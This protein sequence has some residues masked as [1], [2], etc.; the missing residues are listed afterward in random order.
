MLR[1]QSPSAPLRGP[2]DDGP[3]VGHV[4]IR[5][6]VAIPLRPEE[7]TVAEVFKGAG[8]VTGAV[9][10]WGW[11]SK[12]RPHTGRQGFDEWF[13]YLSQTHAHDY[14]PTSSGA[15]AQPDDGSAD[16]RRAGSAAR[17]A[18]VGPSG[19]TPRALHH[20]GDQ[21]Y[22]VNKSV[23][24][25][26]NLACT[27]PHANNELKTRAWKCLRRPVLRPH[28]PNRKE[29]G[30]HITRLD[31]DVAGWWPAQGPSGSRATGRL[32]TSDNGPHKEGGVKA[33][34]LRAPVRL[35]ASTRRVRGR[36]PRAHDRALAR[37]G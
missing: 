14:Y 36:H 9:G 8:Y 23:P 19:S 12:A 4:G 5:G 7:V 2:F 13:G 1:R 10:K 30:R 27:H 34:F 32:F 11:A 35:A 33:E 18:A 17:N 21:L 20:D 22:R 25:F 31:A 24:F 15:V 26:S 37:A 6:N 29:Q 16:R 3:H 28:C